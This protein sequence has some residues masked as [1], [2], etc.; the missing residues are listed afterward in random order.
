MAHLKCDAHNRRV[1]VLPNG[2]TF[3]RNGN[4]SMCSDPMPLRIGN[5]RLTS[6]AIAATNR[7][8]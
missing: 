8:T 6:G 7:S 1:I 4:G 2:K 3:H 5:T